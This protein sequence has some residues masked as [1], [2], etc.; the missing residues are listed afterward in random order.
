MHT[1][2]VVEALL[3]GQIGYLRLYLYE[4][5]PE[6]C[7]EDRSSRLLD[8]DFFTRLLTLPNVLVTVHQAFFTVYVLTTI[9]TGAM[10]AVADFAAG[11][12]LPFALVRAP[13]PTV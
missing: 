9:A 5:Q 12:L 1:A 13:V 6:L 3:A 2:A 11:R 4:D 8:D 10:Q 7:Y